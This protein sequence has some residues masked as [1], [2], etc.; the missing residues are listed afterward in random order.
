[1]EIKVRPIQHKRHPVRKL[2]VSL[3]ADALKRTEEDTIKLLNI[4]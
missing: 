2:F 1:M 3:I 4:K